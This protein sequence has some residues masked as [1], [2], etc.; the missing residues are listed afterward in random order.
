MVDVRFS[1]GLPSIEVAPGTTILE[2]AHRAGILLESPCNGVGTCGKCTVRL[3]VEFLRNIAIKG[4]RTEKRSVKNKVEILSCQAE[5]LGD[6]TVEIHDRGKNDTLEI[7][8][9]GERG[10]I[11]P[12]PWIKRIY[13]ETERATSVF[14]WDRLLAKEQ[15]DTR[16]THF[17]VVVDIGTTTL[18]SSLVD[19]ST[20]REVATASALNPQ[21]RHAHDVLSRI[22]FA[23]EGAGL[24]TMHAEL[25][26]EINRLITDL[27]VQSGVDVR[28]IYEVVYSGNTCM[29]HL[30]TGADPATLGKYPYIPLI[31][32]GNHV[33]AKRLDL[34]IADSGIVYLPPVISGYVGADITSGILA[35]GLHQREETTL[36]IDIGTNGEIVIGRN[37]HLRATSTAAGPAFEGMNISCGMRASRG[38]VEFFAIAEDGTITVR[39]IG[40]AKATGVCGS[41]LLDIV[42]ELVEHGVISDTGR[43]VEPDK[44]PSPLKERLVKRE[45]RPIFHV[46]EGVFLTQKDV[47]QVQL[48]KGA[49]R[50]G[51]E[52]LLGDIGIDAGEVD[53]VLIAGSFGYH[54]REKSLINLG[55]LP[56]EFAGKIDFVGNTSKSGGQAFLLNCGFRDEMAALVNN[57][58]VIELANFPDF[59]KVFVKYLGF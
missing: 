49:V 50:T 19:L 34:N 51:I 55:L 26:L 6:I 30:A 16:T 1:P 14:A 43:I 56:G 59:D 47:R 7:L 53:R 10:A 48:A 57:I 18:V 21:S 2:A 11:E 3:E 4:S 54:I 28:S 29:L 27:S 15:G 41:G 9:H 40:A 13:D 25:V 31:S 35:T 12:N 38:A 5:V 44:A 22:R 39:T 42:A 17:G 23:S 37:G 33:P 24:R 32:G 20:G 8:T 46:A 36:L 52:F 58:E 45:G